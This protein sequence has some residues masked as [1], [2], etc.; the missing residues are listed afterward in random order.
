MDQALI[1]QLADLSFTER[2]HNVVLIGGPGTGKTHLAIAM[3]VAGITQHGR[4]VRFY[5]TVDL[6][7]ALEQEK[8]Q[9]KAGRITASLLN[10]DL[11]VASRMIIGS[12]DKQLRAFS[13]PAL[14]GLN[15][16]SGLQG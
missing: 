14:H 8:A 11:V 1:K 2:A 16:C 5:S 13:V 15:R 7:N 10:M 3:G 9:G 6:V 4:R 12:L